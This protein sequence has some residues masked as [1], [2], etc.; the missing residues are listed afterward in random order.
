MRAMANQ[1]VLAEVADFHIGGLTVRP[2]WRQVIAGGAVEVLQP[3]VMQVLIALAERRGDVISRDV[4]MA[5][6]WGG[7]AVSDD[8]IQRC[9][10]RL[11]RLSETHG[12]LT[13]ETV[14]RVGYQLR[15]TNTATKPV[16]LARAA[17]LAAGLGFGVLLFAAG[18]FC[19]RL[20]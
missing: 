4:L 7:F 19:A 9:I 1:I 5:R 18:F 3:R 15:E 6:C 16:R 17:M 20:L 8:A 14:P 13:I 10:A 12:G 2:R 11:R